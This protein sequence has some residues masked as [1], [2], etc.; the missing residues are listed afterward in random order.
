MNFSCYLKFG[1]RFHPPTRA[2]SRINVGLSPPTLMGR[3]GA[4]EGMYSRRRTGTGTQALSPPA[5]VERPGYFVIETRADGGG[6]P[7]P[8]FESSRRRF[9]SRARGPRVAA[10]QRMRRARRLASSAFRAVYSP[11]ALLASVRDGLR[12]GARAHIGLPRRRASDGRTVHV[13]PAGCIASAASPGR[14]DRRRG[15]LLSRSDQGDSGV[16][17]STTRH[18]SPPPT[19]VSSPFCGVSA[20]IWGHPDT[21]GRAQQPRILAEYEAARS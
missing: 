2:K 1:A 6:Y 9:T 14:R 5:P 7:V 21:T 16:S 17:S 19:T 4:P 18:Q 10:A 11:F 3:A 15:R 8:A 20:F 12:V 13:D